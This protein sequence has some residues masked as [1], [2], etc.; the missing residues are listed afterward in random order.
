MESNRT[1]VAASDCKKHV[2]ALHKTVKECYE[3]LMT[4]ETLNYDLVTGTKIRIVKASKHIPC[5]DLS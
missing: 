2:E 3:A 4:R 5:V 1:F